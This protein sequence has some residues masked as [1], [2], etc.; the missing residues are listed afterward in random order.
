MTLQRKQRGRS[1]LLILL[2]IALYNF[3]NANA[4]TKRVIR[5]PTRQHHD[6]NRIWQDT[7][8][9]RRRLEEQE[10]KTID[11]EAIGKCQMCTDA[12]RAEEGSEC[13]KTGRHIQYKCTESN[14]GESH[15]MMCCEARHINSSCTMYFVRTKEEEIS[16]SVSYKSCHRTEADEE[17]LMVRL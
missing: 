12:E 14:G 6:L 17:F 8:R 2:A 16:S 5:P 15:D 1:L 4:V 3:Q 13:A 7:R 9:W 11:C 10:T